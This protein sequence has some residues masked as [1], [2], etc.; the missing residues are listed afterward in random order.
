MVEVV[1]LIFYAPWMEHIC[2]YDLDKNTL[3]NMILNFDP[4]ETL[5]AR[6]L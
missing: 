1:V 5:L 3:E 4:Y 2:K 6:I